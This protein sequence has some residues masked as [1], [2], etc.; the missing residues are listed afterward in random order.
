MGFLLPEFYHPSNETLTPPL[1]YVWRQSGDSGKTRRKN[2]SSFLLVLPS[3]L[4]KIID[5]WQQMNKI[6][7]KS[8]QGKPNVRILPRENLQQNGSHE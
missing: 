6:R 5:S 2:L 7:K 8:Q 3:P 4:P 1:F